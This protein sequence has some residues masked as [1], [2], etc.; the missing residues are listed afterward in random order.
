MLELLISMIIAPLPA[1]EYED[2]S[3][4][5]ETCIWDAGNMGNGVGDSFISITKGDEDIAIYIP[6]PLAEALT[7]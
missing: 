7:H 1:C 5:A 4:Q 3:G 6:Q 2:G